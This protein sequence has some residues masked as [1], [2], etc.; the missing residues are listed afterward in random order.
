VE[1]ELRGDGAW[2]VVVRRSGDSFAFVLCRLDRDGWS[3]EDD[4][5]MGASANAVRS[6]WFSLLDFD[7]DGPNVGVDISWG[8]A[9]PGA[10]LA[11]L[12][13]GDETFTAVVHAG[14]YWLVRWNVPDPAEDVDFDEEIELTGFA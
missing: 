9:P 8:S 4:G 5:A 6:T 11:T 3:V 14:T 10:E 2:A 1:V 13:S 12:R 7:E